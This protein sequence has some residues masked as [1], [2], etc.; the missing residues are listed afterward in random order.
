MDGHAVGSVPPLSRPRLAANQH[1]QGIL[2][3][4]R[5]EFEQ[6]VVPRDALRPMA[7]PGDFERK[8]RQRME[9]LE[10]GNFPAF[11]RSARKNSRP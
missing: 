1:M 10:E 6:S 11:G 4:A 9:D 3:R 7:T 8:V 2:E 5:P